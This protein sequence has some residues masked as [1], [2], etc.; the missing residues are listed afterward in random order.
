MNK[1]VKVC[2]MLTAVFAVMGI[3]LCGIGTAAGAT[4][5]STRKELSDSTLGKWI[6]RLERWSWNWNGWDW[7][8]SWSNDDTDELSTNETYTYEKEE[9]KNLNIDLNAGE[10]TIAESSD[11]SIH[12]QV[13]SR[14]SKVTVNVE[15]ETLS[16]GDQTK[17]YGVN[18]KME[19]KLLLP[20]GMEF[21]ELVM[22]IDAGQV[23]S[24]HKTLSAQ[25]VTLKVDAGELK[26]SNLT[27]EQSMEV[28]V[29]AGSANISDLSAKDVDLDSGVGELV[30]KGT[31]TGDL[32]GKS[33]VGSLKIVLAGS[34]KDFNYDLKC[35]IGSI[36][37][38]SFSYG[39]L[40]N[41]MTL[42]NDADQEMSLDCGVGSIEV[43]FN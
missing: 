37:V 4:S 24:Q 12:V 34:E 14:R 33:G 40:G 9:V 26:V 21:D 16:I 31:V 6:D 20:E 42:G 13:R 18:M 36:S 30:L 39:S 38:G 5:L 15:N 32:T 8:W 27:A 2:L 10:L 28:T 1:F 23:D 41:G 35:G 7:G 22:D 29:G 43:K 25:D 17:Y 3:L 19:I 11:D